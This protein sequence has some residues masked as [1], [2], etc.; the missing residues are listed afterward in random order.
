MYTTCKGEK[1]SGDSGSS[2]SNGPDSGVKIGL[3]VY[4]WK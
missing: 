4:S 3:A 2:S 1:H